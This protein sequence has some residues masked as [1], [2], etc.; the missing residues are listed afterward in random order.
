[1]ARSGYSATE[2]RI[3]TIGPHPTPED[4]MHPLVRRTATT[5]LAATGCLALSVAPAAATVS[6]ATA[7]GYQ[8]FLTSDD[9]PDGISLACV[10]GQ[11]QVDGD[12]VMACGAV[13]NLFVSGEGGSD[14]I[15]LSAVT[16]AA[17]PALVVVVVDGGTGSDTIDGTQTADKIEDATDDVVSGHGGDDLISRAVTASGGAGDDRLVNISTAVDG[18]AGDDRIENPATG[19]IFGGPGT[20]TVA[21]DY[22][23]VTAGIDMSFSI[24]PDNIHVSAPAVPIEGDVSLGAVEVLEMRLAPAGTQTADLRTYPGSG[25]IHGLGGRDVLRGGRAENFLYGDAGADQL[26]GGPSFDYLDGGADADVVDARD[27]GIDRVRCGSGTDTVLADRV[28]LLADCEKVVLPAPVTSKVRGPAKVARGTRASFGFSSDVAGATF[29]CR[30]D[31]GSWKRCRS[32]Y[33][34]ATGRLKPGRHVLAVRAVAGSTDASPST[35]RFR[36]TARTQA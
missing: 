25:D 7:G 18:G 14:D 17:F 13:K 19:P 16:E 9:D 35:R 29:Q 26:T 6:H 20:D 12:D 33:R 32:P 28:D 11:A 5:A 8:V 30:L 31:Q 3:P 21:L 36:V 15:D 27:G 1:M 10:G 23:S 4:P 34:L 24:T 22:S 2:V